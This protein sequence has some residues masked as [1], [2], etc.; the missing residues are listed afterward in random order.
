MKQISANNL[1]AMV[2]NNAIDEA[3]GKIGIKT[4]SHRVYLVKIILRKS[5][6]HKVKTGIP[7]FAFAKSIGDK[8]AVKFLANGAV[9]VLEDFNIRMVS[10]VRG[11]FTVSGVTYGIKDTINGFPRYKVKGE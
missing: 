6:T 8:L 1:N 3:L 5:P 11:D 4:R 10:E 9:A 7:L 2:A